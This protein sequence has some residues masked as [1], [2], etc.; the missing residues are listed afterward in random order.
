MLYVPKSALPEHTH[1]FFKIPNKDYGKRRGEPEYFSFLQDN[2]GPYYLLPRNYPIHELCDLPIDD[3][4][5]EGKE[6]K[7]SRPLRT[8][9]MYQTR[10]VHSVMGD[11][12]DQTICAPCGSG[13]T[14]IGTNIISVYG[15]KVAVVVPN[16][17]LMFQ[18]AERAK[19]DLGVEATFYYGEK[20][21]I[22]DLTICTISSV[23]GKMPSEIPG[24]HDVGL[25]LGDESHLQG[26]LKWSQ[27]VMP[28]NASLRIALTATP[29]RQDGLD[30]LMYYNFGEIKSRVEHAEL[31]A[32]GAVLVPDILEIRIKDP[33]YIVRKPVKED[34]KKA[35]DPD[36]F[37][38]RNNK[39]PPVG[40]LDYVKTLSEMA[41]SIKRND[42]ILYNLEQSLSNGR[43]CLLMVNRREHVTYLCDELY[44][45]GYNN[46]FF[47]ALWGDSTGD[48]D[49]E[50]H[51]VI[52]GMSNLVKL[53]LDY[54]WLD[55]FM[56]CYPYSEPGLTEQAAGR[57]SRPYAGKKQPLIIEMVD[58]AAY[59]FI[60]MY[61]KRKHVYAKLGCKVREF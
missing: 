47:G 16:K 8:P 11:P 56:P 37:F 26:A 28:F 4:T 22:S 5:V 39:K 20:K 9:R 23:Y 33:S 58:D 41:R 18:W 6:V 27:A 34:K 42:V 32:S 52:I 2:G 3:R 14:T 19:Q 61:E 59:E 44:R 48:E 1:G 21:S 35:Y 60:K 15:R 57:V 53:G 30:K 40:E 45:R 12:S 25:L 29:D 36:L 17:K 38:D 24:F 49:F 43:R 46:E 51:R 7:F 31:V 54:P 55:T 50:N 13:K 10:V